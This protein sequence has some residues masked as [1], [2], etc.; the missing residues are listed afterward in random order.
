MIP[1]MILAIESPQDRD[2]MEALY[3]HYNR[4]IF[5]EVKKIL[6][7]D[8]DSE[9]VMQMVLIRLIGHIPKLRTMDRNHAVNYII[10]TARHA[11]YNF[12]R[13][14]KRVVELPFDE[15]FDM[16]DET[17]ISV[18][19]RLITLEMIENAGMAWQSL[20]ER[21][22]RILEMKYILDT[23]NEEI[24]QEFGVATNSVRMLLCRARD[25]LKTAV[26]DAAPA[27]NN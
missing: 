16:A 12:L 22:R 13:D 11:A 5:S 20:D 18:D 21:S 19:E 1:L 25:K 7:N 8:W 2:F 14:N 26:T 4:L 9:D 3:L 27:Q 23:S 6:K 15:T 10:V 24:A 17:L